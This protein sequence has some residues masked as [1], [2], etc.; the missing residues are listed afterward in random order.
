MDP[1]RQDIKKLL[2]SCNSI[3]LEKDDIIEILDGRVDKII[4]KHRGED[5][6]FSQ[7]IS[8]REDMKDDGI[9]DTQQYSKEMAEQIITAF[10][11]NYDEQAWRN[12]IDLRSKKSKKAK[13][14]VREFEEA[15]AI[16]VQLRRQFNL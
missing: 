7:A 10:N 1:L 4:A 11:Q 14:E 15:L 6:V 9:I 8:P 12:I 13:R 3:I 2:D 16:A 5:E